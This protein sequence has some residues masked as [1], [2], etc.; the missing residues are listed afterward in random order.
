MLK[1]FKNILLLVL[2]FGLGFYFRADL[3]MFKNQMQARYFPCK[4]PISYS[5]NSFDARFG[6]SEEYFIEALKD[7]EE[8]WEKS[9]GIDLFVMEEEGQ[10]GVSLIYDT[11]QA[12]TKKLKD[13]GEVVEESRESYDAMK[14]Q[15]NSVVS[16]YKRMESEFNTRVDR[17]ESRKVQYENDV[18]AANKRGG[19]TKAEYERLNTEKVYLEKEV[20]EINKL[21]TQLNAM[22]GNVNSLA[23]SLNDLAK[24]LNINVDEFNEVGGTLGSEFEEG[25]YIQDAEGQ[26]I[27]IYQFEDRTKLVR[28]LAHELGH[29]LGLDHVEDTNAIMYYLNNG[30][31]ESLTAADLSALKKHCGVTQ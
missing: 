26:R 17:F 16:T 3:V 8:I 30:A 9:S 29:A 19:A 22:V 24:K 23:R 21:Q 15:Y 31:N 5:L 12:T 13:I 1:L 6:I 2:V 20:I 28:V 27:E 25:T 7:A 4:Q 18:R 14:S 11:R 10:V